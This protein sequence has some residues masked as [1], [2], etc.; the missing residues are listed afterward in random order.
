MPTMQG[1]SGKPD[2]SQD[3]VQA[4]GSLATTIGGAVVFSKEL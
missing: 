1:V 4:R 2:D 3:A